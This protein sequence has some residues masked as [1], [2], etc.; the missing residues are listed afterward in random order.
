LRTIA[1]FQ[2]Q[3]RRSDTRRPHF[4]L[5]WLTIVWAMS[6]ILSLGQHLGQT[7]T[8]NPFSQMADG[9]G[10]VEQNDYDWHN[11]GKARKYRDLS[12][13]LSLSLTICVPS[14]SLLCKNN[15]WSGFLE[16]LSDEYQSSKKGCQPERR[17]SPANVSGQI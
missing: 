8:R 9:D 13:S 16:F 4:P 2:P 7:S 1:G 15:F 17:T 12:F 5:N 11:T 14:L 3:N 6:C 10:D